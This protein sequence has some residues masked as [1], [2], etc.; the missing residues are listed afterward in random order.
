[1]KLITTILFQVFSN[2][3]ILLAANNFIPN[4]SFQGNLLELLI[5]ALVL[6]AINIVIKPILKL[7]LTPLIIITF[8]LFIFLINSGLL[9]ILDILIKPLRMQGIIPLLLGALLISLINFLVNAGAKI[10]YRKK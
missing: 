5:T 3:V 2:V 4:F 10:K 7:V 1:M 9:L 6:T 8:G